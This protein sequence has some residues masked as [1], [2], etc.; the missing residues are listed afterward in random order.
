MLTR[1][2]VQSNLVKKDEFQIGRILQDVKFLSKC[3][4]FYYNYDQCLKDTLGE[5]HTCK[6]YRK[7]LQQCEKL[8]LF[9]ERALKKLNISPQKI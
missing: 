3:S 8:H 4:E 1:K 6:D 9:N 7:S 2:K 5:T